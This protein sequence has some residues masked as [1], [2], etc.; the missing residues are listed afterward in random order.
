MLKFLVTQRANSKPLYA[1]NMERI[2]LW[3]SVRVNEYVGQ[4]GPSPGHPRKSRGFLAKLSA[5]MVHANIETYGM[6][7]IQHG[8]YKCNS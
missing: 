3:L 7:N 8:S 1:E 2:Q 5:R 6:L 4:N